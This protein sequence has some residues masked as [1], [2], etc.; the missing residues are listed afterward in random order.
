MHSLKNTLRTAVLYQIVCLLIHFSEMACVTLPVAFTSPSTTLRSN[1]AAG[2]PI[3]LKMIFFGNK[4]IQF[5]NIKF[6]IGCFVCAVR[7]SNDLS[8]PAFCF[9]YNAHAVIMP[10]NPAQQGQ[11]RT[12]DQICFPVVCHQYGNKISKMNK[13]CKCS[14]CRKYDQRQSSWRH[15]LRHDVRHGDDI[16]CSRKY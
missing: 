4:E 14:A 8:G 5:I 2:L 12:G 9:W 13:S 3:K 15:H 11:W 10:A 6:M 7:G 1:H 16:P